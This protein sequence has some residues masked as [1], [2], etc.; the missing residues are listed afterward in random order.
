MHARQHGNEPEHRVSSP[1]ELKE[2]LRVITPGVWMILTVII[3]LLG[4]MIA[5]SAMTTLE[6]SVVGRGRAVQDNPSWDL[7]VELP[8]GQEER[9]KSDMTV[10]AGGSTGKVLYT[11]EESRKTYAAVA[12]DKDTRPLADGEYE[13]V[14]KV[15]DIRPIRFLWN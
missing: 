12:M 3:V 6:S 13:A 9:V 4:G 1:K 7:L 2:Y 5:F 10:R 8:E 15:E 11:F 14:I